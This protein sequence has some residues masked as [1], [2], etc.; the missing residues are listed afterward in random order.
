MSCKTSS[1]LVNVPVYLYT[2]SFLTSSQMNKQKCRC[3]FRLWTFFVCLFQDP[4]G[5]K[6]TITQWRVT[7]IAL[8]ENVI[9]QTQPSI[10]ATRV[11]QFQT[12]INIII[13]VFNA[14]QVETIMFNQPLKCCV[15]SI[16]YYLS[17]KNNSN[18]LPR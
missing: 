11:C 1:G 5:H 4:E 14:F 10:I 15:P 8:K 13:Q 18:K 16:Q 3:K 17:S 2:T 12:E 6:L 7:R 9:Q